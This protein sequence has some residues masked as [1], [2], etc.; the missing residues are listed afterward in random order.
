MSEPRGKPSVRAEAGDHGMGTESPGDQTLGNSQVWGG[1]GFRLK[2]Q[3]GRGTR[4]G[5]KVRLDEE[6]GREKGKS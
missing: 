3:Q 2:S 4:P 5:W 6:V 1:G